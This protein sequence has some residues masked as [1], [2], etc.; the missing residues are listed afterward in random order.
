MF[1]GAFCLF[2]KVWRKFKGQHDQGQQDREPLRGKSFFE[3]ASERVFRG[4]PRPSQRQ[5]SLSEAL[6]PVAPNR[7]AP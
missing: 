4:P 7:F 3:R 2:F 1:W 6:S 5:I